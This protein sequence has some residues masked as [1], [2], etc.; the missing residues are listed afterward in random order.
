[1]SALEF[2]HRVLIVA[3]VV[4]A[5]VYGILFVMGDEEPEPTYEP[6]THYPGILGAGEQWSCGDPPRYYHEDPGF[7]VVQP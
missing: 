2:T 3:S 1:M 5:A 7:C 4:V 6:P